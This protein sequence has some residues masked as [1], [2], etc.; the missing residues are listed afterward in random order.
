MPRT[1]I[2]TGSTA[3]Y[4]PLLCGMLSSIFPYAAQDGIAIGVFSLGL[5]VEQQRILENKGIRVV[6]PNWV[7]DIGNFTEPAPEFFKSMTARPHLPRFFPG[8]DIYMWIDAD[9]WVQDWQAVRTFIHYSDKYGFAAVPESDRSYHPFVDDVAVTDH[10]F[11]CFV[12]CGLDEARAGKL[13][14]Y[15]IINSGVIAG[16]RDAPHWA[17]WSKT[18]GDVLAYRNTY[19]FFFEQTVLNLVIRTNAIGTAF[20]PSRFNWVCH[21]ARPVLAA[22]GTTLLDAQAPFEPLGI[23]HLT[24]ETKN[25]TRKL[26]DQNGGIHEK[27]LRFPGPALF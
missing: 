7:Y 9:C 19:S 16:R 22:D 18:L 11:K 27:S 10:L 14:Q 5:T 13:A 21:R 12:E 17:K 20:L 25:D 3:D 8:Y 6:E 4:F 2:I 24:Y 1:I 26:L 23:I 15:P